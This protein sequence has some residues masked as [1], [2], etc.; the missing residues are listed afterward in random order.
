MLGRQYYDELE[1]LRSQAN[2]NDY[3]AAASALRWLKLAS[4]QGEADATRTLIPLF[5]AK[6]DLPGAIFAAA[7]WVRQRS[8][9]H[10]ER[11]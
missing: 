3:Q 10:S 6:G 11:A 1:R 8:V 9:P 5:I 4:E 7:A 2:V